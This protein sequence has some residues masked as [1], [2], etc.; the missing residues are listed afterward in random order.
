[1][2]AEN[3]S[4]Q[5]KVQELRES[6][7][8]RHPPHLID[9]FAEDL[10][11][12]LPDQFPSEE[13]AAKLNAYVRHRN[14]INPHV[15]LLLVRELQAVARRASGYAN[16][17]AKGLEVSSSI[18]VV[19]AEDERHH[20]RAPTEPH[21]RTAGNGHA[22]AEI[23]RCNTQQALKTDNSHSRSV[24]SPSKAKSRILVGSSS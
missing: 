5:P 15:R 7:S 6:V 8:T 14:D 22:I 20:T 2:H 18:R 24:G 12:R 23:E 21:A 11:Y 13:M 19:E 17:L 9:D 10:A 3:G 1:M 4:R 16:Q